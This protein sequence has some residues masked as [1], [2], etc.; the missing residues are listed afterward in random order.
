M[1]AGGQTLVVGGVGGQILVPSL[2][3]LAAQHALEFCGF[4]GV[5]AAVA[6][7]GLVPLSFVAGSAVD[8][9]TVLVIGLLGHLKGALLVLL[10]IKRF[11][12]QY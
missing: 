12:A 11:K 5:L 2:G 8:G 3:Q 1:L 7:Q 10:V 6:D 4:A 9:L